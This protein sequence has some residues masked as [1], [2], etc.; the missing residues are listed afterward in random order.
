MH[1]TRVIS[2]TMADRRR[3][4]SKGGEGV[5]EGGREAVRAGTSSIHL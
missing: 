5:G 4:K 2:A 1:A 3:P